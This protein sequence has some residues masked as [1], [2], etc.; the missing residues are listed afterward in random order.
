MKNDGAIVRIIMGSVS[1]M[2]TMAAARDM[3]EELGIPFEM[4]VV[5]AH[6]TPDEMFEYAET[7]ADRGLK[8]IIAGAGGAA[9]LPGIVASKTQLPVIG[10]PV[11]SRALNGL[12]SLLSIVQMPA[13]VPVA[14]MAI[15][16]AANAALFAARIIALQDT[17]VAGRLA[18]YVDRMREAVTSIKL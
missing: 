7:A 17:E 13:G 8:A 2:E 15:G 14:T 3:L 16:N 6:R 5:S 11:K 18:A 12:D 1:D 9:H 4:R 10:V